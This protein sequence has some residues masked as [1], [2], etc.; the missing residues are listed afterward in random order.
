[1]NRIK[2]EHRSCCPA[3][4]L[5]RLP[6]APLAAL[7]AALVALAPGCSHY[8]T[9][10]RLPAHIRTVYI[11]TFENST[12]EYFLPQLITD[13]VIDRFLSEANLRLGESEQADAALTGTVRAYYEEAETFGRQQQLSVTSRRVTIVLD[14]EFADRVESETLWRDRNFSRWVVYEPE[15]ESEEEAAR[16][17][18]LLLADDLISAVLQQW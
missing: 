10:G 17:A 18:V 9:T 2:P 1:M 12:A 4:L 6:A 16:R 7:L 14:V 13:E 3:G 8:S 11:P 5:A 15:Q